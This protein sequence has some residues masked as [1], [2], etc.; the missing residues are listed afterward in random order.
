[1]RLFPKQGEN[2]KG[3]RRPFA[4]VYGLWQIFVKR[5]SVD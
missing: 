1:M 5:K 2:V 3:F 4:V